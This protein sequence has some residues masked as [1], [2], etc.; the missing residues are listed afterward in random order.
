V[1][2][3][4]QQC[5]FHICLFQTIATA[6][7]C[8]L[9]RFFAGLGVALLSATSSLYQ[10]RTAS[11]GSEAA[12]VG[13]INGAITIGLF[14][15]SIVGI[16]QEPKYTGVFIVS[17]RSQVCWVSPV[18]HLKKRFIEPVLGNYHGSAACW[19]L[20]ETPRYSSRKADMTKQQ[21]P[22]RR[23]APPCDHTALMESG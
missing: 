16:L 11:Q 14:M 7:Q 15:A 12:I 10:Q 21:S 13:C 20:P 3:D 4:F 8:L 5:V 18:Q 17:H 23:L 22:L 6:S 2:P 1:L 9:R 19:F